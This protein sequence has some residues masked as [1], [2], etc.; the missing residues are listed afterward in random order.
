MKK[1]NYEHNFSRQFPVVL[2]DRTRYLK[3]KKILKVIMD[4]SKKSG[5]DLRK[6]TV[7]DVGCSGGHVLKTLSPY[8]QKLVGI[9]I[10]TSAIDFAKKRNNAP[11]VDY[12]QGDGLFIP[13][14][15]NSFNVIICNHIYE[16]VPDAKLLFSEI[17]RVLKPGGFCYLSAGNRLVLKEGH[18]K[19][20]FLSWLPKPLAN[21]YLRL[22]GKGTNYY[23]KHLTW[24]GISR[25]I[26]KFVVTDYTIP[27]I[28]A[29]GSFH[30]TDM[31]KK[32]SL[33][34]KLPASITKVLYWLIPTYILILSKEK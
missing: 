26:K 30:A 27:I 28:K 22:T 32:D 13:F 4:Y 11:N 33:L 16:H 19:L 6:L 7:L 3:S 29:P 34:T 25:I 5:F 17:R 21:Y 23:E 18:Y 14:K 31:I 8:F 2:E 15:D 1:L 10:D 20:Y 9:D 24:W 12:L